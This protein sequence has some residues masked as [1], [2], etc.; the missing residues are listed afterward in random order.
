ME[1]LQVT[2]KQLNE[3][4]Q[5]LETQLVERMADQVHKHSPR[6]LGHSPPT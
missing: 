3:A 6:C 4:V 2:N 5:S 1:A